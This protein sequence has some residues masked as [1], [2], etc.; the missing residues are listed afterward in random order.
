MKNVDL[1]WLLYYIPCHCEDKKN[2]NILTDI[3]LTFYWCEKMYENV[4]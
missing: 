1:F 2:R 3:N 4:D